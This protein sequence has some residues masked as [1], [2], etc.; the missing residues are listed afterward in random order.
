MPSGQLEV[1][2]EVE[3]LWSAVGIVDLSPI[4]QKCSN[5]FS[6]DFV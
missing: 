2:T 5:I 6:Q 1:Y 3:F 4:P